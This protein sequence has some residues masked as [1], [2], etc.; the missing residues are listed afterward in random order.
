MERVEST[1]IIGTS[2][3]TRSL[4][5]T[6][7]ALKAILKVIGVFG[8]SLVMSGK[9]TLLAGVNVALTYSDG[10]LTPAQSVLGAIQG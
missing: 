6:S 2:K 9:L 5:E 8:V 1:E 10:V 4:L 3:S 7:S